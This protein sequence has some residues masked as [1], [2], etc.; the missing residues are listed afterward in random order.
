[1]PPASCMPPTWLLP[2]ALRCAAQEAGLVPLPPRCAAQPFATLTCAC[3]SSAE[4]GDAVHDRYL[5]ARLERER[6]RLAD[7][8]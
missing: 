7:A 8:R 6:E 1:M 4:C 3:P 5:L 2:P